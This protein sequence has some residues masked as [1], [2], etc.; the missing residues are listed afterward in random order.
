M[1]ICWYK[2]KNINT[3]NSN[4]PS[5]KVVS[6]ESQPNSPRGR[7]PEVFQQPLEW[8]Y[9]YAVL[10]ADSNITNCRHMYLQSLYIQGTVL[11][12]LLWVAGYTAGLSICDQQQRRPDMSRFPLTVQFARMTQILNRS[13]IW[14]EMKALIEWILVFELTYIPI[15]G[16]GH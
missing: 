6:V 15:T 13:R 9:C 7:T 5:A 12:N 14:T 1:S 11:C 16:V 2:E 3:W 10:M 4:N 8:E